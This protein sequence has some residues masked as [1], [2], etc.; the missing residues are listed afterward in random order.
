MPLPL[1]R[2]APNAREPGPT[3]PEGDINLYLFYLF[4]ALAIAYAVFAS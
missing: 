4:V 2:L 3:D 1:T